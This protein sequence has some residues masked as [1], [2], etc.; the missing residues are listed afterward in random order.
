MTKY[1]RT[2]RTEWS[3]VFLIVDDAGLRDRALGHEHLREERIDEIIHPVSR[4]GLV[5]VSE[6]QVHVDDLAQRLVFP[7]DARAGRI[8]AVAQLP[9]RVCQWQNP[10]G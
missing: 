5:L 1:R 3:G 6:P 8:A 9:V 2:P 4:A 7:R 10:C